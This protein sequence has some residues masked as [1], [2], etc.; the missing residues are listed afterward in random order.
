MIAQEA[1]KIIAEKGI[2]QF[3]QAKFK[4]AKNLNAMNNGCLP[5]NS[6]VEKKLIE[7]YQLFQADVDFDHI[8]SLRKIALM[9]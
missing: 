1:A 9:R 2:Q 6:D 5:S 3:G 4:A 7:Y 8:L